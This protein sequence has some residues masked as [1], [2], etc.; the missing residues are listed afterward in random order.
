[1]SYYNYVVVV[2]T[3]G[4]EFNV[5]DLDFRT[6]GQMLPSGAIPLA[7]VNFNTHQYFEVINTHEPEFIM[8]WLDGQFE[9]DEALYINDFM[10]SDEQPEPVN[11]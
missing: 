5:D 9:S 7:I 2:F 3:V 11:A 10:K 1:M 4:N 8:N 6:A